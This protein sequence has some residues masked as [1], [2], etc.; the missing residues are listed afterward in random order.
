MYDVGVIDEEDDDKLS[1]ILADIATFKK[2]EEDEKVGRQVALHLNEKILDSVMADQQE[3]TGIKSYD[4][5]AESAKFE[6]RKRAELIQDSDEEEE[7]SDVRQ[8]IEPLRARA[9]GD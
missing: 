3:R 8:Q 7:S 6:E 4:E 1:K 9:I 2:I 5:T